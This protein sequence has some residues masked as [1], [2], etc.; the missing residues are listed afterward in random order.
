MFQ[1]KYFYIL[2]ISVFIIGCAKDEDDGHTHQNEVTFSIQNPVEGQEFANGDTIFMKGTVTA[3]ES[4]HG[5]ELV[6][7][8][9]SNGSTL[10]TDRDHVH[11][12]TL[13]LNKFFINKVV[14]PRQLAI[15]FKVAIDHDGN[16]AEKVVKV[17]AK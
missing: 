4:L 6:I 11:G 5:Y 8:D 3:E 10:F 1:S 15:T 14:S 17:N 13:T 2:L 7:K 9:L 12:N 16:T